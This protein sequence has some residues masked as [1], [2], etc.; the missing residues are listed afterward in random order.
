ML[1]SP[2]IAELIANENESEDKND[3]HKDTDAQLTNVS[4][5]FAQWVQQER[6]P[7]F[8]KVILLLSLI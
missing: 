1:F 8:V 5:Q 7:Q 3:K 6:F 2:K 4:S